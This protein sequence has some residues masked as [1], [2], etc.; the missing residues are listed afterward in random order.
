MSEEVETVEM[1]TI[2]LHMGSKPVTIFV[3]ARD[4]EQQEQYLGSGPVT[5]D[6]YEIMSHK[7]IGEITINRKNIAAIQVD[8]G[9]THVKRQ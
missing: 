9:V 2:K 1:K 6:Y 4:W 8:K 7:H 3:E 5:F